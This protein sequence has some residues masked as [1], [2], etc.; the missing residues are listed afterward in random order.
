[1]Q[2]IEGQSYIQDDE[3]MDEYN[4]DDLEAQSPK[5]DL[6]GQSLAKGSTN[7]PIHGNQEDRGE[8]SANK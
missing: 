6:K 1:M 8:T 2:V 5:V 4:E 7:A 3:D